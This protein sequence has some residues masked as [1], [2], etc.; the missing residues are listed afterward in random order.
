M[1]V[2][3][4]VSL[5]VGCGAAGAATYDVR[6]ITKGGV[7]DN[8]A[9]VSSLTDGKT[10]REPGN[11][12]ATWAISLY[13]PS[14][15]HEMP[16]ELKAGQI[17]ILKTPSDGDAYKMMIDSS[18]LEINIETGELHGISLSCS[19]NEIQSYVPA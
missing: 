10:F 14:G 16:A 13:A 5:T 19:A 11:L 3:S 9:Y 17:I 18:D 8:K 6:T 12:D 1:S 2:Q 7:A 15:I 4:A